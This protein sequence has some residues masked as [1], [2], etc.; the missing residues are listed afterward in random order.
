LKSFQNESFINSKNHFETCIKGFLWSN[1][2]LKT[3]TIGFLQDQISNNTS[4][5]I[6]KS[7]ICTLNYQ[8]S[9][10]NEHNENIMVREISSK[11]TKQ[12]NYCFETLT[13][14]I[15]QTPNKGENKKQREKTQV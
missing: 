7:S 13:N 10:C 5:N 1:K 6:T 8:R 3:E 2:K 9:W 14:F 4:L 15:Q 11:H 12:T